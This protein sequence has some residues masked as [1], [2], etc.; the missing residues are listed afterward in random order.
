[1]R[2]QPDGA[3][4]EFLLAGVPESLEYYVDAGGVRSKTYRFNVIDLPAVKRS[5]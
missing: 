3:G 4:Y 1:M 2:P 5:A